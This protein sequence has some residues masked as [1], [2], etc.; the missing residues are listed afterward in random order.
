[1]LTIAASISF[2]I[3]L[4]KASAPLKASGAGIGQGLRLSPSCGTLTPASRPA[5]R[6]RA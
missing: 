6:L 4:D 2:R 5:R 3:K 1:M